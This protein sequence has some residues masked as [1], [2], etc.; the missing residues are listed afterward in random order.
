MIRY[1]T[2]LIEDDPFAQEML[3]DLL[4][5]YDAYGIIGTFSTVKAS[6]KALPSLSPDLVFLDMELPDGKD[7]IYYSNCPRSISRLS[8]PLRM[9]PTCCKRSNIVPSITC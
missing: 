4:T 8:L 5:E 6:L 9:I 1:K 3:S 2:V 7:L